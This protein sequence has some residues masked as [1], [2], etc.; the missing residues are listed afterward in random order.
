M[1]ILIGSRNEKKARE[2]SELLADLGIEVQTVASFAP[3]LASPEETGTTFEDN[4]RLK[5]LHFASGSGEIV[6]ADDSGLEVDALGGAPGVYSSRYAGR[7]G[8]DEAN[9]AKLLAEL[10]AVP[11]QART[12]R[13]RTVVCLASPGSIHLETTGV[14][15]GRI[16][17]AARGE[18]GFGYDPLFFHEGFGRSFAELSA[19]EKASVSHRGQAMAELKRMLPAVLTIIRNRRAF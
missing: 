13:F 18:G 6:V 8:D 15:E 2:M 12:A 14:V 16:L 5:A 17:H 3:E 10:A 19:A 11:D 9:N 4:A 1:R 7:D